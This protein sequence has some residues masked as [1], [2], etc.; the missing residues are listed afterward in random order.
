MKIPCFFLVFCL[1]REYITPFLF[2]VSVYSFHA[3]HFFS[4][5][6]PKQSHFCS[7]FFEVIFPKDLIDSCYTKSYVQKSALFITPHINKV[8]KPSHFQTGTTTR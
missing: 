6:Q 3:Y 1:Y 2:Y 8:G 7:F 4:P 5:L